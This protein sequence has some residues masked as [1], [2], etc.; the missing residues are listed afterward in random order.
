LA[1]RRAG[2]IG[3]SGPYA[4]CRGDDEERLVEFSPT[5]ELTRTIEVVSKNLESMG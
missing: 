5:D 1:G 3:R 2:P 4:G